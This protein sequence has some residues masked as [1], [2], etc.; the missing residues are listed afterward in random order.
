MPEIEYE[1]S[2]TGIDDTKEYRRHGEDADPVSVLYSLDDVDPNAG[3]RAFVYD[4]KQD[5]VAEVP[6]PATISLLGLS[7]L[8]LI[9]KRR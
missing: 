3:L 4:G 6:E 5:N 2:D 8:A 1:G 9:R 7:S